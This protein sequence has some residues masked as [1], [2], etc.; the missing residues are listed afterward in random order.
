MMIIQQFYRKGSRKIWRGC[1]GGDIY[2][3]S[4]AHEIGTRGA[5]KVLVAVKILSK[6]KVFLTQVPTRMSEVFFEAFNKGSIAFNDT[7]LPS[8]L[9]HIDFRNVRPIDIRCLRSFNW[10]IG[11]RTFKTEG[12]FR[13]TQNFNIPSVSNL[14]ICEKHRWPQNRVPRL[15]TSEKKFRAS[16]WNLG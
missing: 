2:P 3:I 15:H 13:R 6:F 16:S 11:S 8:P 7:S 4:N 5:I 1:T 12:N 10:E 14:K 9:I